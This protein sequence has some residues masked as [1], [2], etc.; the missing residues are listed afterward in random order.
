MY[1][2]THT[3]IQIAVVILF[4]LILL[5]A[6]RYTLRYYFAKKEQYTLVA[7][8]TI[9][10][11]VISLSIVM[12]HYLMG[13]PYVVERTAIYYYVVYGMIG[14]TLIHQATTRLYAYYIL[15]A[16]LMLYHFVASVNLDH[17]PLWRADMYTELILLELDSSQR[18]Q[19]RTITLGIDRVNEPVVEF[20]MLQHSITS[21]HPFIISNSTQK[22][23]IY[24]V[25]EETYRTYLQSPPIVDR[26]NYPDA[27]MILFTLN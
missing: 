4:S 14:L 9:M 15:G 17:I 27:R 5:G 21:I 11:L 8:M 16:S 1:E 18:M 3:S 25:S 10:F 24:Y 13:T 12:Q 7:N 19:D 2:N 26:K 22:P 23:D 6:L 20:Y